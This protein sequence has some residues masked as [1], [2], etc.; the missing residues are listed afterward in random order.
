MNA[1]VS[2]AGA[3]PGA[4]AGLVQ[5]NAQVP[6]GLPPTTGAPVIVKIGGWTSTP[7]VTVAIK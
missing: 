2:F 7:N 4:I 6:T 5:I 1:P 3:V